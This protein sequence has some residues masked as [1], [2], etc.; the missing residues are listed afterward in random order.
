[1]AKLVTDPSYI[2]GVKFNKQ[3][4]G[5][6][7]LNSIA[8][9]FLEGKA[10][11]KRAAFNFI[12]DCGNSIVAR[13]KDVKSGKIK[14]CG[15]LSIETK[16]KNGKANK[17][18]DCRAIV[19]NIWNRFKQNAKKRNIYVD[20]KKSDMEEFLLQPCHYCGSEKTN[21]YKSKANYCKD[22]F[23]NG[24]DRLDSNKPYQKNNIVPCCKHCNWAKNKQTV[25]EYEAWIERLIK[26]R[27]I[28][29]EAKTVNAETPIPC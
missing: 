13:A 6:L 21:H 7:T 18:P 14:S 24:I 28:K 2:S 17:L 23:Y 22:F 3:K 4:Y 26:H 10:Q 15:C 8:G 19:N 12:C 11:K 25:E 9:Y 5:R 16:S 29:N 20:I 27:S 1:M